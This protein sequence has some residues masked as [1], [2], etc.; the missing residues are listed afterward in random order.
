MPSTIFDFT[1]P[2]NYTFQNVQVNGVVAS[3]LPSVPGTTQNRTSN[4]GTPSDYT[5]NNTLIQ[6]AASQANL[7]DLRPANSTFFVAGTTF[8]ANWGN[9]VLTATSFGS[10]AIISNKISLSGANTYV[11]WVAASNVSLIQTG[12][13]RLTVTPNYTGTPA[14][15][16]H[17]YTSSASSS[18]PANLIQIEHNSDGNIYVQMFDGVGAGLFTVFGAFSPTAGTAYEIEFDFNISTGA[19]RLFINGTQLG[20]TDTTTGTRNSTTGLLYSGSNFTSSEMLPDYSLSNFILF[21]T[22]QH[23]TDYA[24]GAVISPTIF[25]TTNPPI[26][27]TTQS[28]VNEP[29]LGAITSI[30]ATITASGGDAVQF[31]VSL[32]QGV[33]LI[34]WN[35]TAWVPSDGTFSQTNTLAVLNTN[36][37]S[38]N[39]A[40]GNFE[41][42]AVM[43]S[44]NGATTPILAAVVVN[45]YDLVYGNG[46]ILS[47]S[48]FT[49]EE[50]TA[51]IANVSIVGSDSV[52]YAFQVNSQLV[53]WD[54]AMWSASDGTLAQTNA[55]S[56]VQANILS[57]LSVNSFVA[58]YILLHSNTGSTTPTVT[59][60]R[61]TYNFGSVTNTPPATCIVY[62]FI[63][64]IQGNPIQGLIVT[65]Q[66]VSSIKQGYMEAVSNVLFPSTAM[67]TTDVNG[68][69][70]Q[71]LVASVQFEG[72]N[73]FIR[74]SISDGTQIESNGSNGQ[75]LTLVIP[76]QASIDITSLLSA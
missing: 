40:A 46:T 28:L 51:M 14:T 48:T 20:A 76:I 25:T 55:L 42:Y 23:T 59:S 56:V 49:A 27:F 12:T 71:P 8:H 24:P 38:L 39:L 43:H 1:V 66:L 30:T 44:V 64:D 29:A 35:G 17:F 26:S 37:A 68:Y 45:F 4:F 32:T 18:D 60:I 9:G 19:N 13:I 57:L 61:I 63:R 54:G 73:T 50:L 15:P 72:V 34:Y 2:S 3:L 10:A 74:V 69:F 22:V 6:I 58:P 41:L 52:T 65:F 33:S 67:A 36:L 75:P 11:S 53:Y 16:Q 21:S 7:L 62:G 31:V 70:Q 5:Y 47:N